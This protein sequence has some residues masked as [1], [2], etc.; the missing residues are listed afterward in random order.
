MSQIS[1]AIFNQIGKKSHCHAFKTTSKF[2][3]NC[4]PKLR[5]SVV[6]I[7]DW[8][9][10]HVLSMPSKSGFPHAEIHVSCINALNFNIVILINPIKDGSQSLNVP[11]LKD[12]KKSRQIKESQVPWSFLDRFWFNVFWLFGMIMQNSNMKS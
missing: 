6:Q 2:G 12:D 8:M 1:W 3:W 11:F 10:I 4:V 9:Q 5:F 7:I